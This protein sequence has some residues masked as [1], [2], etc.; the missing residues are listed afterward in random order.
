MCRELPESA[1]SEAFEI[2]DDNV[3]RL[4][5]FRKWRGRRRRTEYSSLVFVCRE[6]VYHVYKNDCNFNQD[7]DIIRARVPGTGTPGT[8]ASTV[9]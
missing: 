2:L 4:K 3:S 1:A 6:V 7:E 5:F 8:S 9:Q